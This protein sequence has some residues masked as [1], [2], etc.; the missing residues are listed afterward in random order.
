MKTNLELIVDIDEIYGFIPDNS[1]IHKYTTVFCNIL[2][3]S[4]QI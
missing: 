4:G 1:V 2:F 3:Y